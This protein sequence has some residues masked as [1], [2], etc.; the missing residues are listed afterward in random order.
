MLDV[1]K[2]RGSVLLLGDDAVVRGA[3]EAGVSFSSTYPG[4]PVSEVGDLFCKV[5]KDTGVHF[6]Y[7][8][9]E[10]VAA[11][12]AAG[13]AFSGLRSMVSF[14][15]FGFN[16]A[17]DSVF[18]LA[19]HGVKAGMV[20]VFSDDPNCWS[21]GQSEQDTRFFA[22]I[23]HMPMLEPSDSQETKDFTKY[24]FDLSEKYK[25][26]V[27]VRLTTRVAYGKT[28]VKLGPIKKGKS[29]GSAKFGKQDKWSTMPPKIIERHAELHDIIRKLENESAKSG[30]NKVV[31]GERGGIGLVASGVSYNHCLEACDKLGL[32]L[33]ILKLSFYPYPRKEIANFM[34]EYQLKEV[35]AVE[36]I[37]DFM[38]QQVKQVVADE[39]MNVKV[40]GKDLIQ[41]WGEMRTEKVVSALGNMLKMEIPE[42]KKT[43]G[44]VFKREP[45]LCPG[46]PHRASFWNIKQVAGMENV[47]GGDIGCYILGIFKPI[48]MQDY[49]I[50]MGAG[51]GIAHGIQRA[52]GKTVISF[53]GD[54]TFFHAGLPEIANAVY[55]Q[56][57]MII[58]VLDNGITAMTGQQPNPGAGIK[59]GESAPKISIE[60]VCRAMGAEVAVVNPFNTKKMQEV[61]KEMKEKK[62]V[63]IIVSRQPCR[64]MFMRNAKKNKV[65]VPVYQIDQKLCRKCGKCNEY[66][67]PAIHYDKKKNLYYIDETMCWGCTVCSQICPYGAIK[68]KTDESKK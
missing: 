50:S 30:L 21:S 24:A 65:K 37:E 59:C 10:K 47:Y 19:Y 5:S 25:I 62:G 26:P 44:D 46:C 56:S 16:V 39:G 11:E 18:P 52:T 3:L 9:N 64:L 40:R 17:S 58:V 45:I 36:E 53:M 51:T 35:L 31:K 23:G 41:P 38:E 32:R 67:C 2:P 27:L 66:G 4:T 68:P 60:D 13:V 7:C 8:T 1:L 63:R 14:K 43:P 12:V 29:I 42:E 6:E 49:I 34:K 48:E 55:N 15:H 33:P 20:I 57:N 22:E 61:V 54:S 28:I